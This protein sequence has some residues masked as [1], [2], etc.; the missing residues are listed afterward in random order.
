MT[1]DFTAEFQQADV[2]GF[3]L[4]DGVGGVSEMYP[5]YQSAVTALIALKESGQTLPGCT[6]ADDA[7]P[8][9]T[10]IY[11]CE[12]PVANLSNENARFLLGALGLPTDDLYGEATAEDMRGRI[13][14]AQAIGPVD[15]GHPALTSRRPDGSVFAVVGGREPHYLQERL[16][17]LVKVVDWCQAHSRQI[18]WG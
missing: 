18:T 6:D 7:G 17:D 8:V 4:D 11:T 16:D 5:T 3:R 14:L 1:V 13:L 15:A 12:P 10:S 2:A 9:I